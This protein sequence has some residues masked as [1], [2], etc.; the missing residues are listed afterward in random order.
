MEDT[1]NSFIMKERDMTNR[2]EELKKNI[3]E[4]SAFL[5]GGTH[6]EVRI[7]YTET[8]LTRFVFDL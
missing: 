8:C 4:Y 2:I 7:S 3:S 1:K 6:Q 5:S